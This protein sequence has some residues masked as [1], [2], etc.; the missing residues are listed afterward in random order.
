MATQAEQKSDRILT[1]ARAAREAVF[2]EME[3]DPSI[4]MIG[5]DIAQFG[6]VFGTADGLA[7]KFGAHRVID[8]PI[9]ETGFIGIATGAAMYGMR[10]IVELAYVDFVGVCFNA[11]YNY[12]AKTHYMSGGQIKTP[13]VLQFGVGGGYSNAA[14][15]SQCLYATLA[16]M[17]GLKVVS[18]S[19]AYDAKG[20]MRSALRDDNVVV[21]MPHK[22]LAGLG[23]LGGTPKSAMS[24]VPQG[25]YTVPIGKA[26]VVREGD[27]VTLVGLAW[28]VHHAL[29]AADRLAEDGISAEVIDIRTLVPLDR[30]TIFN[31]VKKTG[32]LVVSDEDYLSYGVTS[33]IAA[34]IAERD[35]SCLKAP[36]RRIAF[37]DI[38][39]PYSRP[40]EQ[41]A[42]PNVEKI[43]KAAK[44]LM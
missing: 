16:H 35:P 17:P 41:F 5:E 27:D 40:M 2:E 8:T 28:T 7:A 4:F 26:A 24:V 13:M 29:Q 10:P 30:D 34:L 18:P 3:R 9:S 36:V 43:Y 25:E 11:V 23:F 14:Q 20:L 21:Y 1:M 42:L 32:R 19:N 6:G 39:I 12:A 38:P 31:S 22:A 15:H 37:P 44:G 33:E